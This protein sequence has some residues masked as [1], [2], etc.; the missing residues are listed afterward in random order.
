S[1]EAQGL[2]A[3]HDVRVGSVPRQL[4][5][6][7]LGCRGTDPTCTTRSEGSPCASCG[8]TTSSEGVPGR[9][10]PVKVKVSSLVVAGSACSTQVVQPLP[11][12]WRSRRRARST[13]RTTDYVQAY[14]FSCE[15]EVR[16]TVSFAPHV[17]A[18]GSGLCQSFSWFY[19]GCSSV[20]FV[21][22]CRG[23]RTHP[24]GLAGLEYYPP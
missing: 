20:G 23:F 24:S 11:A 13:R 14:P 7:R 10:Y 22:Y 2:R 15:V 19:D 1:P 12:H 8:R 17:F 6:R 4:G 21:A 5:L 9:V 16:S 3:D 18:A